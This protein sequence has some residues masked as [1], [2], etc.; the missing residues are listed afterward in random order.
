MKTPLTYY[1]GKQQLASKIVSLIPEHRI[2]C[3]PFIGGAAVFF[4]KPKSQ[5]EIIN[6]IN[7]EIVNFY[8]VLQRDFTALQSEVA[9]SLHSRKLHKH[10]QVIYDNPEMFDRIKRAWAIWMLANGSF[11]CNLTAGCGYDKKVR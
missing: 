1:G 4:A 5:S 6:D 2:Y 11:G 10:A 8:E 7:S 3:E 9:I